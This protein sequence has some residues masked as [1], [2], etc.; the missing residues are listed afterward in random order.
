[1]AAAGVPEGL[2]VVLKKNRLVNNMYDGSFK[3]R[4]VVGPAYDA[5]VAYG[6]SHPEEVRVEIKQISPFVYDVTFWST[7]SKGLGRGG[8]RWR[9]VTH[10]YSS[11]NRV[12][13]TA[14]D[15]DAPIDAFKTVGNQIVLT[16]KHG[17]W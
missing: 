3:L 13:Y 17:Y 1:M 2:S 12:R 14:F 8:G 6:A 4:N 16:E 15:T 9:P 10:R 7:L 5:R 11:D